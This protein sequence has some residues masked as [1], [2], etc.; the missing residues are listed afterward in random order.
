MV[1][2]DLLKNIS[3]GCM[4]FNFNEKNIEQP[5]EHELEI[6]CLFT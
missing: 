6:I 5:L 4:K 3:R 2:E 1:L